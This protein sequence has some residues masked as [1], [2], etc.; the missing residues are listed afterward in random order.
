MRKTWVAAAV[1]V[2]AMVGGI[3]V[4]GGAAASSRPATAA[5]YTPPPIHWGAC[6]SANAGDSAP[7]LQH[8]GAKCG[9]VI[10]PLDYA[11][12][13]GRKI[14]LAISRVLHTTTAPG[15]YHGVMLVNPGGPGESG[16]VYSVF[17]TFVPHNGGAGYDWIGWDP[18]GV[19]N[20]I[21]E[22]TCDPSFFHGDRPPYRPINQS[23]MNAW[24]SR[25]MNYAH[26]C[27]HATGAALFNHVK[28]VDSV[29]DME[30][31]RRALGAA[32]INYYGFSYGTYLG[33]VYMTL[34]PHR[35]GRFIL[36]STVDPRNVW[37]RA[38]EN[39]DVAFQR[40]FDIYFRWLAKYHAVYHVGA[41]HDAVRNLFLNIE[42]RLNRHPANGFLGGDELLD[43]FTSAAYYVYGWEDI[44]SAYSR[45]VH[46]GRAG[47]LIQMYKQSNPTTPGGDNSYALYL[48]TQCTDAAWPTNQARLNA[49]NWRL[50][51]TYN[52][53]TWANA[54]FNG[55]CPYWHYPHSQPVTVSGA[56]V[57][58]PILMIDE[59]F[60]AATPFEGSLYVRSIFPTASLIEGKN[61]ST[62][63]GSLSGVACTDN[64]IAWYLLT[65]LVPLR[66]TGNRSDKVCPPV[67]QPNPSASGAAQPNV[68]AAL[69][70][71]PTF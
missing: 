63:A 64:T 27:T 66:R 50:D 41:T 17:Q 42:T 12:P 33:S 53:F 32:K 22:L 30:S 9:Y 25:S 5:P 62:H 43:V 23:I 51:Q 60:D 39:Q 52:Y 55:P 3:E 47:K 71:R 4:P 19:G 8:Y 68:A 44:A 49:D 46:T 26:E 29:R 36:D 57:H 56:N 70:A 2:V 38:N 18:R 34:H 15:Q 45:F 20:S 1:A 7:I 21:P 6:T 59:T 54:W 13:H 48:G 10:V 67:P 35:V 37:Y 58:V 24:V 28:T 65:G 14:K 61:G 31:I 40:T 69:L 11:H 16:L